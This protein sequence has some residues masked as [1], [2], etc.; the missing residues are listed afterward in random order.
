MYGLENIITGARLSNITE[1][2]SL[3]SDYNPEGEMFSLL[4]LPK[5]DSSME[6]GDWVKIKAMLP[7]SDGQFVDVPVR[8]GEW[9]EM[10]FKALKAGS[11]DLTEL[12]VW[13]SIMKNYKM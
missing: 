3:S 6:D 1:L 4:L 2:T 5:D 9:Q 12:E 8:V 7:Y 10:V 11:I 13:V